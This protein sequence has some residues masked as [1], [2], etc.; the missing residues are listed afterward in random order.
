MSV[1]LENPHNGERYVD[2]KARMESIHGSSDELSRQIK[3]HYA[4]NKDFSYVQ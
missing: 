3:V 2:Y 4:D 1:E